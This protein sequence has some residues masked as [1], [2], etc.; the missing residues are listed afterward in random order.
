M[1]LF[2]EAFHPSR[3]IADVVAALHDCY[4]TSSC[5]LSRSRLQAIRGLPR[6]L[7]PS[8]VQ[9][10]AVL[11]MLLLSLHS[12]CP[13]LPHLRIF[14]FTDSGSVLIWLYGS[15]F[16]IWFG[17]KILSIFIMHFLWKASSLFLS[18]HLCPIQ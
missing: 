10:N 8:S 14:I 2:R 1:R 9:V 17:Q 11:A 3:S 15:S 18:T 6:L 4:S 16:E 5:S 12:T 13:I 7:L